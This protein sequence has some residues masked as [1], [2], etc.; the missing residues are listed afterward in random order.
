MAKFK[1][2]PSNNLSGTIEVYGAKNAAMK[3]IAASV[4]IQ[5]KV[6]LENVPEIV[7]VQRLI[8][9]LIKNGAQ[10]TRHNHTLTIDTTN[11]SNDNPDR[12]LVKRFRGSIV[13]VG[14]YLSRFGKIGIPQ[15]GGCVIGSRSIDTH[16]EAFKKIGA[17]VT[18]ANDFNELVLEKNLGGKVELKEASVTATENIIMSQ[19]LGNQETIIKNAATEPQIADLANFLNKAGAKITGAGEKT[20][21]IEGVDTLN[22]ITYAVMPDPF[23]ACTFI[24]L[25]IATNSEIKITNCIPKDLFPFLDV[26]RNM[27]V[28]LEQ[29]ENYIL[30]KKSPNLKPVDI[31]T[32]IH[33]GFSTDMQAPMGLVLTQAHGKSKIK[34]TLFE[35]RLGYLKELVE[36]GAQVE[37]LNNR[38]AI[39]TG[40]TRL[41]GRRID[42]LDLRAGA[43]LL[44]AGLIADTPTE[45][46]NAENIDR[47]YERI[48]ERL[49]K[50]G[51]KIQ[52]VK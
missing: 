42:S 36:M 31:T 44:I 29:G 28:Q 37:F 5:G 13:L 46:N 10:I 49:A 40:P 27:G 21:R 1:I 35:N 3:M 14:P 50:I 23:E 52:R 43:T 8:E 25:A 22:P 16:L 19:V 11:L 2:I 30:V 34:E 47:G 48:E 7:D 12:T 41:R 18:N 24:C 15:P 32:G 39:I 4:L 26:I 9:I 45:I 38:E 17:K 20:I 33:P 6:V 51:A